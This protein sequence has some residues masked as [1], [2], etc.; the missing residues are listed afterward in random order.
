MNT[1]KHTRILQTNVL[2]VYYTFLGIILTIKTMPGTSLL[3]IH[4]A[5]VLDSYWIKHNAIWQSNA[6]M[7]PFCFRFQSKF[8]NIGCI[9]WSCLSIVSIL[10]KLV[11][12]QQQ[13]KNMLAEISE[14][15]PKR[16]CKSDQEVTCPYVNQLLMC[17]LC[18]WC[19]HR[20]ANNSV[21][22]CNKHR[23]EQKWKQSSSQI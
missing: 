21:L 8:D 20:T 18:T 15:M 11:K 6:V 10:I 2:L 9:I 23:K 1:C 17:L 22:K 19:G 5:W 7:L 4:L 14:Q 13:K 3:E 16:I 12:K